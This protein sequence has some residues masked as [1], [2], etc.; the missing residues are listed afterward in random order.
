MGR[1]THGKTPDEQSVGE[2]LI[3]L[4]AMKQKKSVPAFPLS[5]SSRKTE[6]DFY[7]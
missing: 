4:S 7:F 3:L 2:A 1:A 6:T 5:A